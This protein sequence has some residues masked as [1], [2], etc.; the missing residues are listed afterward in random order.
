MKEYFIIRLFPEP[1]PQTNI[2]KTLT[3]SGFQKTDA[4]QFPSNSIT[5]PHIL[6]QKK[7]LSV[8]R[9]SNLFIRPQAAHHPSRPHRDPRIS[10]REK[11][12]RATLTEIPA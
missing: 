10:T 11:R 7:I 6:K 3:G 1:I 9:G 2:N 4:M 12:I 5:V 8:R